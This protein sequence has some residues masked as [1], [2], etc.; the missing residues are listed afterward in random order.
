MTVTPSAL[1]EKQQTNNS[2]PYTAKLPCL[3]RGSFCSF[4]KCFPSFYAVGKIAKNGWRA[5]FG[6]AMPS[7][8]ASMLAL[9]RP[10]HT[11]DLTI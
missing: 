9:H 4:R 7:D 3:L 10:Q 8:W 5:A 6:I 1:N 11:S 2:L